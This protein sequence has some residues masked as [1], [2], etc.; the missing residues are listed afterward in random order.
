MGCSGCYFLRCKGRSSRSVTSIRGSAS[1]RVPQLQGGIMPY[2]ED[3]ETLRQALRE[4]EKYTAILEDK[5]NRLEAERMTNEEEAKYRGTWR[6]WVLTA[7]VQACIGLFLVMTLKVWVITMVFVTA[8][9]TLV[10]GIIIGCSRN[11]V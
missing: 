7:L 1:I 6:W 8:I 9:T 3:T 5:I 2:R 11:N 10:T 4:E